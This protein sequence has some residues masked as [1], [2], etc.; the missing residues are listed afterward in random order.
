M[1]PNIHSLLEAEHIEFAYPDG[2]TGLNRLSMTIQQGRKVAIVGANGSGKS[3][4]FLH[5]NG[6]LKPRRGAIRFQGKEL[7]YS[8][9]GLRELRS[10]IGLVF[11][12][13]DV[14]LFSASVEQDISFGPLNMGLSPAEA[15]QRVDE[16]LEVT[17]I[18]DLRHRPVHGL[19]YGQKK[20][21]CIAGIYA[22]KPEVIILDEPLAWLDPVGAKHILALLDRLHEAGTTV[23]MSLHQMDIVARWAQDVIVLHKGE[24]VFEGNPLSLFAQDDLLH[25]C[26][27]ETPWPHEM[28]HDLVRMGLL[29]P[30]EAAPVDKSG[31]LDMINRKFCKR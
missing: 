23:I 7:D 3:T 15:R 9:K 10:R 29:P 18:G 27:L 26:G 24:T 6:T 12:D 30:G 14:Q 11:Q 13:P 20:R 21:V 16:A 2:T 31:L 25:R 5:L 22:M 4:L 28:Y 8:R 1:N 17:G 19:S